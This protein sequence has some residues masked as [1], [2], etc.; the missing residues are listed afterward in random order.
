MLARVSHADLV[1]L[2]DLIE[3]GKLKPV[4]DRCYPLPQAQAAYRYAE[5]RHARAKVVVTMAGGEAPGDEAG[6]LV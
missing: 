1:V 4:I 2:K 5:T 6:T 3:A